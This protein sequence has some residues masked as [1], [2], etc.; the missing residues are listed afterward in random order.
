M[1]IINF[2]FSL[3]NIWISFLSYRAITWSANGNLLYAFG[4]MKLMRY[5]WVQSEFVE[6]KFITI[7]PMGMVEPIARGLQWISKTKVLVTFRDHCSFYDTSLC[8]LIVSHSWTNATEQPRVTSYRNL[9][10][11][12]P[13]VL[14]EL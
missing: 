6:D 9:E 10:I 11:S 12:S 8:H 1:L 14:N 13:Y 7:N 5:K 3:D 4:N 2:P